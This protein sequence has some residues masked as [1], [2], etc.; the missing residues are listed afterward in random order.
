LLTFYLLTETAGSLFSLQ[1]RLTLSFSHYQYEHS[2]SFF[3]LSP[4]FFKKKHFRENQTKNISY[5]IPF[6]SNHLLKRFKAASDHKNEKRKK[7][8]LI[9]L[10]L[11]LDQIGSRP[12]E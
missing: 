10:L 4:L 8:K 9:P 6:F 12:D 1:Q 7:R 5:L 11:L 3:F 2:A